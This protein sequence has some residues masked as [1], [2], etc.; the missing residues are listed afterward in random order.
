MAAAA[1]LP[2]AAALTTNFY[3]DWNLDVAGS[4]N[5]TTIRPGG[6][7]TKPDQNDPTIMYTWTGETLTLT[8]S[9]AGR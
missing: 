9:S 6:S 8:S 3:C 7:C 1:E 5:A 4:G 2:S